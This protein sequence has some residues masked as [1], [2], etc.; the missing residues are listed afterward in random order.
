MQNTYTGITSITMGGA[1]LTYYNVTT[2]PGTNPVSVQGAG[3]FNGTVLFNGNGQIDGTST[4]NGNVVFLSDGRINSN[5]TYNASLKFTSGKSYIV[6][7]GA[8]QTFA[9]TGTLGFIA[10]GSPCAP[11]A[12]SSSVN[13]SITTFTKSSG[14]VCADFLYLNSV[15]ATGGATW[16]A[17]LNSTN[18]TPATGTGWQTVACSTPL[19][20]SIITASGPLCG[21][22]S[23]TLSSRTAT[24]Y[25]WSTGAT[26][27]SIVITEAGTYTLSIVNLNGC[28]ESGSLTIASSAVPA[29]SIAG[30][31]STCPSA[32]ETYSGPAG[33][34]G[35]AWSI[36]GPGAIPG[37]AI[38]STV[39]VVPTSCGAYTVSVGVTNA[40]GCTSNC[41]TITGVVDV[42]PPTINC[43]ADITTAHATGL[44]GKNVSFSVTASDNCG[45]PTI[46]STP[47]SGTFFAKGSTTVTSVAT[48]ACGN[49]STCTFTV[50][51]TADPLSV[52]ATNTNVSCNGATTGTAS[53][54]VTGGSGTYSYSWSGGAT[55]AN[56]TGLAAGTYTV[57]VSDGG[58]FA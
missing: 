35:Y 50:T 11:I 23:V 25:L 32:T 45:T 21:S 3:T 16:S 17:G 42:T 46:V 13:G 14:E 43:P 33:M 38:S 34:A 47:A 10:V 58:W 28:S 2:E 54:T 29:C 8:T 31:T 15:K 26:T 52:T 18:T 53:T 39:G 12:I 6:G 37:S 4:F 57:V 20:S 40:A 51:V 7:S 56:P 30:A 1:G 48:D 22:G 49:S 5:N 24:S 55:G 19:Q 41:S 44:C 9:G 36:S 27:Q